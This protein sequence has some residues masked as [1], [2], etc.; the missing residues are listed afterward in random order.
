MQLHVQTQTL[1]LLCGVNNLKFLFIVS[2]HTS[3]VILLFII[4]LR[5]CACMAFMHNQV[6]RS[7]ENGSVYKIGFA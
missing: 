3:A 5:E 6:G 4:Y 2:A 7:P 1:L